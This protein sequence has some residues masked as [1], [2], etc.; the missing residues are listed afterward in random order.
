MPTDRKIDLHSVDPKVP[1]NSIR[2][3]LP[4]DYDESKDTDLFTVNGPK[5]YKI[6]SNQALEVVQFDEIFQPG[7]AILKEKK[8]TAAYPKFNEHG[9]DNLVTDLVLDGKERE[10]V[11]YLNS[12]E[13]AFSGMEMSCVSAKNVSLLIAER[14]SVK[15]LNYYKK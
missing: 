11:Y 15:S 12:M 2:L 5:L 7:Y 10:R 14:E 9:H 8:W 13:W 1:Y 4:C 3:H 6:D